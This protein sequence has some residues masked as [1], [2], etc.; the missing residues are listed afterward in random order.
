MN[1]VLK[2]KYTEFCHKLDKLIKIAKRD[3]ERK[4]SAKYHDSKK[5]WQY[6]N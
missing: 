4:V 2:L 6:I 3:F 1:L 5:L